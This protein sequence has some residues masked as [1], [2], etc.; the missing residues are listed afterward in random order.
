MKKNKIF[1]FSNI[2]YYLIIFFLFQIPLNAQTIYYLDATL[3]NDLND[4]LSTNTSWKTLNKL[5][6]SIFS[7]GDIIK[8]KAGET[9]TGRLIISSSGTS[10]SPIIYDSYGNGDLPILDGQG[11]VNAVFAENKE[12]LEFKNL[13]ITNF[14]DGTITSSDRFNAMMFESDDYGTVNHLR[15]D[16]ITVYD[17][18]SSS[19]DSQSLTRYYGG[20][21]FYAKGSNVKSNFNDLVVKNSTFENIGRTGVN[22]RSEWWYRNRDTSFGDDLGDGRLDNWYA[23]TN[24]IFKDNIFRNIRGNGLIVRVT[25]DALVEG[26]LF[27]YCADTISGNAT[28]NFNTDG[29]IFQFNEAK[30]TVYNVGD[31]DARGI[32]SD[33]RVKN[34]IIQYNYL[35]DN[36][37]GGIVATG[38]PE[39]AGTYPERFNIGT[40]IR[41]NI[42]ENNGRQGMHFSGAIDGLEV[43]NNVLYADDTHNNIAILNFKKWQVYP[44]NLNFRNNIFFFE[45]GTTAFVYNDGDPSSLGATNVTFSNNVYFGPQSA[46]IPIAANSQSMPNVT[47]DTNY[48]LGSPLFVDP[49]NGADGYIITGGS[50]A[51]N[52][53][54]DFNQPVNDYY[55][56]VIN[57]SN[58]NIGAYQGVLAEA[59]VPTTS[60][61]R[62]EVI[63]DAHTRGDTNNLDVNYGSANLVE[64]KDVSTTIPRTGM[65]KFNMPSGLTNVLSAKI[66]VFASISRVDELQDD[67]EIYEYPNTW[68][69]GSITE[70]NRPSMGNKIGTVT[71]FGDTGEYAWYAID[72]T[73]YF[74]NNLSTSSISI[75]IQG[76][77]EANGGYQALGRFTSKEGAGGIGPNT[78]AAYIEIET[79]TLGLNDYQGLNHTFKLYPNPARSYFTIERFFKNT[80]TLKVGIYNLQGKKINDFVENVQ[81]G[82]WK[83]TFNIEKLG[84]QRGVYIIKTAS[85]ENGDMSSKILIN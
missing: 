66:K 14:R 8:F 76:V 64:A 57:T 40:I 45:T 29:T 74:N 3:G 77:L 25:T 10:G 70:N 78:N 1:F 22:I 32:D 19:S 6:N 52:A 72:I 7:A 39:V 20:I 44:N 69:E 63:E 67:F 81:P 61:T 49:G 16:N 53:G 13:K 37:L 24:V 71:I 65:F 5:N 48:S 30:N 23:S 17:V 83:K 68:S 60:T 46:N 75:A 79:T 9:F 2:N 18:N 4:G 58:I 56:N 33:Y 54:V 21:L 80:D 38:G 50:S 31:T 15:F 84:L 42:L 73:D 47:K 55:G 62:T 51:A 11:S 26:N 27:D 36:G 85:S 28:F 82:I 35:H 43:Y 12:Y 41:Y 59:V 34:T